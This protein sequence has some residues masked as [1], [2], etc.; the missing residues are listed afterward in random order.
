MKY[1]QAEFGPTSSSYRDPLFRLLQCSEH[2]NWLLYGYH[3]SL[4]PNL[5]RG[6]SLISAPG[7]LIHTFI[8]SE[9]QDDER[10]STWSRYRIKRWASR[11][12]R[13]STPALRTKDGSK[14]RF[15]DIPIALLPGRPPLQLG[16]QEVVNPPNNDVKDPVGRDVFAGVCRWF[17]I[18]AIILPSI[19]PMTLLTR[20]LYMI[21]RETT[22]ALRYLRK[23][24]A[25]FKENY[26]ETKVRLRDA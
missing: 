18:L 13:S 17:S 20:F 24:R 10:A 11:S 2:W 21:G 25:A 3:L 4:L 19:A 8:S 26:H 9:L 16:T 22:F 15:S 14:I 5:P 7:L 6:Q 1:Q 23:N 12:A